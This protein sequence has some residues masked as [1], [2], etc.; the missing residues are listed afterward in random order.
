MSSCRSAE[1]T[2][3][4]LD[5]WLD[6][7]LDGEPL[8][9]VTGRWEPGGLALSGVTPPSGTLL[10]GTEVEVSGGGFLDFELQFI[11]GG[12]FAEVLEKTDD[13]SARVRTPPAVDMQEGPVDVTVLTSDFPGGEA[14]A[15]ETVQEAYTYTPCSNLAPGEWTLALEGAPRAA[16]PTVQDCVLSFDLAVAQGAPAEELLGPLAVDGTWT[17]DYLIG[18][19]LAGT[20]TATL[21]GGD[22]ASALVG[23]IALEGGG[24]LTLSGQAPPPEEPG[25]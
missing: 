20:G 21:S 13:G 5:G 10:G 12:Q 7:R 16:T 6:G 18:G 22:P 2:D 11:F 17:L 15:S 3:L 24:T 8:V 4:S 23:S 1:Q 19:A 25:G 9:A 14:T